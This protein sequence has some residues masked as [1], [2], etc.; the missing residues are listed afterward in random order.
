MF[1]S[2]TWHPHQPA[3]GPLEQLSTVPF[4]VV[5]ITLGVAA[6]SLPSKPEHNTTEDGFGVGKERDDDS[7]GH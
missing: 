3:A 4:H 6:W 1:M 5:S 2:I 7:R